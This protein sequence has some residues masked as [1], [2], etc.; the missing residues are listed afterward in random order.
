MAQGAKNGA[1]IHS[2]MLPDQ[3]PPSLFALSG[4]RTRGHAVGD[5]EDAPRE[6]THPL[7]AGE[8]PPPTDQPTEGAIRGAVDATSAFC[9]RCRR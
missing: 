1:G 2:P 8:S 9:P 7:S 5:V 3:A 6:R 4:F